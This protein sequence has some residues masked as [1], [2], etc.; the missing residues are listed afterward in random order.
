MVLAFIEEG[1]GIP[2]AWSTICVECGGIDNY[3][4]DNQRTQNSFKSLGAI[5]KCIKEDKLRYIESHDFHV[6]MHEVCLPYSMRRAA[7]D[8]VFFLFSI[9]FWKM[10]RSTSIKVLYCLLGTRLWVFLVYL[11]L[12]VV[13][14]WCWMSVE[15][16]VDEVCL[17]L[18]CEGSSAVVLKKIFNE[19]QVYKI[20]NGYR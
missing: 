1:R 10:K 4:G 18:I 8:V 5:H 16:R 11:A 13:Q 2:Q 17:L 7:S 14:N 15:K 19:S 6:Q 12:V 9:N 20:W 3:G